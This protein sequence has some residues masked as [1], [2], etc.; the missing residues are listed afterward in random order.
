[1]PVKTKL[2]MKHLYYFILIILVN[3]ITVSEIQAQKPS[4]HEKDVW[5]REMQQVKNDYISKQLDLS[6]EQRKKFMPLYNRMERDMRRVV[7]DTRKMARQVSQQGEEA[8]ELEYEKAAEAMFECKAKE[9]DV[10]VRYYKEFKKILTPKQLFK[11]KS[12]ERDFTKKLMKEHRKA[13]KENKK[14]KK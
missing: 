5:M 1:M 11:L 10:E 9:G 8:S 12:A 14:R 4:K 7:D 13:K 2:N 3:V 6:V